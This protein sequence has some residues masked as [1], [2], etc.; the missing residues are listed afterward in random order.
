[1]KTAGTPPAVF[2]GPASPLSLLVAEFKY[3]E[4]AAFRAGV[5][6]TLADL[7]KEGRWSLA[8]ACYHGEV[9]LAADR[10]SDRALDNAGTH[11]ELPQHVPILGIHSLHGAM[12][13]AVE[14]QATG[15]RHRT[16][17]ERQFLLDAPYFLLRDRVPGNELTKVATR[18]S[19]HIKIEFRRQIEFSGRV[20][21]FLVGYIHAHVERRQISQSSLCAMGH[22]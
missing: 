9:L 6:H 7:A 2:H 14:H 8:A 18:R 13:I 11:S 12:L 20:L 1:M 16:V 4:D 3:G 22:G 19:R 15:S 10:I 5:D 17:D 21:F